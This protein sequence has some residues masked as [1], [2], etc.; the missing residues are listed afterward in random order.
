MIAE[1]G[2]DTREML[3]RSCERRTPED[4]TEVGLAVDFVVDAGFVDP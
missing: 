4:V 3:R 1:T 2:M